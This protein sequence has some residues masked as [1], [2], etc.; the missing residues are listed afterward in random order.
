VRAVKCPVEGCDQETFYKRFDREEILTT[1][2]KGF[3]GRY[4]PAARHFWARCPIHGPVDPIYPNGHHQTSSDPVGFIADTPSRE[5][6]FAVM[7]S[8]PVPPESAFD[9]LM[10]FFARH[11]IPFIV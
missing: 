7:N 4:K 1:S 9:A 6:E 5:V 3:K 8:N 11:G 2:A 10:G